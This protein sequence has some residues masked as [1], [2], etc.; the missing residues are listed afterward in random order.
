LGALFVGFTVRAASNSQAVRD[1]LGVPEG[2]QVLFSMG[3]GYPNVD[4][5][6]SVP[7]KKLN[8]NYL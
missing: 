7:R 2:Q 5:Q 4:Y 3:V 6:R 1:F 8:V